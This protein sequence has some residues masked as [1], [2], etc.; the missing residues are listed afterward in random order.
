MYVYVNVYIFCLQWKT[1][2]LDKCR[3][4]GWHKLVDLI[5]EKETV[6]LDTKNMLTPKTNC[7]HFHYWK[8]FNNAIVN[9]KTLK[10]LYL[11]RCPPHV[12]EKVISSLPELEVFGALLMK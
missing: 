6:R 10:S 7:S 8:H 4:V 12:V 9:A 1:I 11:Y 2:K 3:V 5:N